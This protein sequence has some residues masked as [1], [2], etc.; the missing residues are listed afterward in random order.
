MSITTA[1]RGRSYCPVLQVSPLSLQSHSC[2][3]AGPGCDTGSQAP[4]S[5]V[6]TAHCS[7]S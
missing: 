1:S 3:V 2:R 5:V 6:L 7:V 4:A